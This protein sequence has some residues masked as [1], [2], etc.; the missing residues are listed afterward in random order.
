MS[1]ESGYIQIRGS[2]IRIYESGSRSR[3]VI[4]GS[5]G[6]GAGVRKMTKYHAMA[7]N[8]LTANGFKSRKNTFL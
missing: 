6:S 7:M 5:S 3:S 4:Y 8:I 1:Y 2:G